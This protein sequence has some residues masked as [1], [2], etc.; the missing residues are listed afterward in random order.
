MPLTPF[1]SPI[2]WGLIVLGTLAVAGIVHIGL[3]LR[4]P[5]YARNDAW[6]RISAQSVA[7][8]MTA[9]TPTVRAA[10]LPFGDA[11]M[12]S[13]VCRY[14]LSAGPL[15]VT[16]TPFD[17]SFV[18]LGFHDR[19]G[20]AFY[21]LNLRADG[22]DPLIMTLLTAAQA[23]ALDASSDP[24]TP[25]RDLRIV[26]PGGLGFVLIETPGGDRALAAEAL[27]HVACKV[28]VSA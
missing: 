5:S 12:A 9:L 1:R 24:E 16:V 15:T 10:T 26:A 13:A 14:D 21:G 17:A 23:E 25:R 3:V 19:G 18:S 22:S 7:N 4:T 27:S 28:A 8:R 2:V 11:A 20:I 6:A